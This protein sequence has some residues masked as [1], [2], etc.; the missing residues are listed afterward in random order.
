MTCQSHPRIEQHRLEKKFLFLWVT[1]QCLSHKTILHLW[2]FSQGKNMPFLFAYLATGHRVLPS[3]Q[4][5]SKGGVWSKRDTRALPACWGHV[6]QPVCIRKAAWFPQHPRISCP[7]ELMET[8]RARSPIPLRL[9][10]WT[11]PSWHV[12][13]IWR[14]AQQHRYFPG[15]W[16]ALKLS[17]GPR[18]NFMTW[19]WTLCA[20]NVISSRL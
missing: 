12:E 1:A 7:P 2:L 15:K 8:R 18:I 4:S 3:E 11:F 17:S 13:R 14:R 16:R 20:A 5:T 9:G 19:E 6:T 10:F